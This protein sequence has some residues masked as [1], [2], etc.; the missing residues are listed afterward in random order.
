M[1]QYLGRFL[2]EHQQ[3]FN[4]PGDP[5]KHNRTTKLRRPDTY[6][7]T[8]RITK[9]EIGPSDKTPLRPSVTYLLREHALFAIDAVPLQFGSSQTTKVTACS[10]IVDI[11]SFITILQNRFSDSIKVGKIFPLFFAQKRRTKYKYDLR[12]LLC[13]CQ[14]W[15]YQPMSWK[16]HQ[17]KKNQIS[18]FFGKRGKSPTFST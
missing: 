5:L 1:V 16:F 2:V 11:Q 15:I 8:I 17:I 7:K 14:Q 12:L 6:C 18:P 10:I 13:F 9:T 4:R 3:L